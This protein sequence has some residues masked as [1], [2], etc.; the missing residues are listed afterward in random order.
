METGENP[1]YRSSAPSNGQIAVMHERKRTK[2]TISLTLPQAKESWE[3]D[4]KE[5]LERAVLVKQKGTQ[6]FKVYSII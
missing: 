4:L 6:Y 5:K 2:L 3:M 1:K